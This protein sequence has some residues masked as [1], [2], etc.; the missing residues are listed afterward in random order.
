LGYV[1]G[2]YYPFFINAI[3]FRDINPNNLMI[4]TNAVT[5]EIQIVLIDFNVARRY[6]DPKTH[7]KVLCLTTTGA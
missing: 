1:I 6:R 4:Q 3:I 5:G 2:I 7:R